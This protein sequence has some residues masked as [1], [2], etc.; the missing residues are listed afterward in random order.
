MSVCL[1]YFLLKARWSICQA[2]L[3]KEDSPD[4]SAECVLLYEIGFPHYLL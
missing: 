4:F 1:P 2:F 3:F